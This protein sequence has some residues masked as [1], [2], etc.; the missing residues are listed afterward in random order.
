MILSSA[1]VVARSL[2]V[3]PS[4]LLIRGSWLM[5]MMIPHGLAG[6][7]GLAETCRV[8]VA[9]LDAART[10]FGTD[11]DAIV[12]EVP[13]AHST[14]VSRVTG[15]RARTIEGIPVPITSGNDA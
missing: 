6:A 4:H 2:T 3:A 5:M 14:A 15:D 7:V 12:I 10:S 1:A 13:P 9:A 8:S 11:E